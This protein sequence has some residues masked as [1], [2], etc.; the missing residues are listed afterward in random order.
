MSAMASQ[1]TSLTIIYSTVYSG[2]DQR[3]DQSS[4][5]LAFVRRIPRWPVNSP[6]KAPVTRKMF[7]FDDVI[8]GLTFNIL[9][10]VIP[11]ARI[12]VVIT[13]CFFL[14]RTGMYIFILIC[15]VMSRRENLSSP[16]W[17]LRYINT[18]LEVSNIRCTLVGNTIVDH[19]DV[20]GASPVGAAPTT[21]S[22]SKSKTFINLLCDWHGH[23]LRREPVEFL[24]LNNSDM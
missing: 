14:D 13:S 12:L 2:T 15:L 11:S 22:F 19:S 20:V 8:L 4:A 7:P 23:V 10:Q 21:S 3:N 9:R 24:V 5:S 6:H 18:Y 1:I 17:S 16:Y